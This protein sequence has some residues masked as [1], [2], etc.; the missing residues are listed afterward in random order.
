MVA[1]AFDPIRLYRAYAVTDD[2]DLLSLVIPH[3]NRVS[4]CK[5]KLL[6]T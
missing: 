5:V 2:G 1:A 4:T 3:D 6:L